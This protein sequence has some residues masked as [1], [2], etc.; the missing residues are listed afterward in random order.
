MT[1]AN[2]LPGTRVLLVDHGDTIGV[3]NGTLGTVTEEENQLGGGPSIGVSW[4]GGVGPAEANARAASQYLAFVWEGYEDDGP[5]GPGEVPVL[6]IV[7]SYRD[8]DMDL[9]DGDRVEFV[10]SLAKDDFLPEVL[11]GAAGPHRGTATVRESE[12]SGD[13]HDDYLAA[14]VNWEDAA[15]NPIEDHRLHHYFPARDTVR[16]IGEGE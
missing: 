14:W 15:G 3:P 9:K 2:D 16:V 8:E 6:R 10:S 4:D 7:R 1:Q 13:R 11:L 5:L 12:T